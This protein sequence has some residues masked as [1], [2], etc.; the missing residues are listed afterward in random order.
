[1]IPIITT[2]DINLVTELN[3]IYYARGGMTGYVSKKKKKT[4]LSLR[5][6][7][8]ALADSFK[9]KHDDEYGTFLS[10][11]ST[12]NP[13]GRGGELRRV[14]SGISKG[15]ENKQYAAQI[16]FVI[17]AVNQCLDVGFYFGRAAAIGLDNTRKAVLESE[18]DKIGSLFYTKVNENIDL[19]NRFYH[20]FELGFKAEIINRVVTP[21]QWLENTN[22]APKHSSVVVSMYPNSFGY[23]D[24]EMIDLFVS[25]VIPFMSIIPERI[26][27][28]TIKKKKKRKITA[29]TPD[30]RAKKAERLAQ[31]GLD[32]EKFVMD[33]EK[34]RLKEKNIIKHGYPCHKALDSDSEGYD[35]MSCNL[36]GDDI[37]IEVKTTT[38]SKDH[39]WS[40]TFFLSSAEFS[41]YEDNKTQYK[42]YRVWDIYNAPFV[43][44][45]DLEKAERRTDGFIVTIKT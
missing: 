44:E 20:L 38:L 24:I 43:E 22:F 34:E 26:S 9:L 10:T 30:Q 33:F 11:N 45:I 27:D 19:K 3:S 17:N 36:D 31:I 13:I 37:F 5:H 32:G 2:E 23:I 6:R 8:R 1:M 21:D 12:G 35:I 25:M 14:W 29:L 4:F 28:L 42:L 40:K 18:L 7:L 39:P 41:F 16:S 15:S